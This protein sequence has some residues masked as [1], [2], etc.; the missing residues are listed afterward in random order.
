MSI[1]HS[2]KN[3]ITEPSD[4][5]SNYDFNLHVVDMGF[6][7][8]CVVKQS[9]TSDGTPAL[10]GCG[11]TIIFNDTTNHHFMMVGIHHL[12]ILSNH[13]TYSVYDSKFE[14]HIYMLVP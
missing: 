7:T 4:V 11:Y 10:V 8:V 6:P 2:I 5:S 12:T 3:S 9:I 13:I 14:C 1:S